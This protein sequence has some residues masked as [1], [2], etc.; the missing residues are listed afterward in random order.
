MRAI[1]RKRILLGLWVVRTA[2]AL[3]KKQGYKSRRKVRASIEAGAL[4][5][6]IS[7]RDY[8]PGNPPRRESHQIPLVL[9]QKKLGGLLMREINSTPGRAGK[10]DSPVAAAMPPQDSEQALWFAEHLQPHEAMLRAWLHSRFP[11]LTDLDDIIQ[12]AYARVLAAHARQ[13]MRSPKAFFFATA[14]NLACD[15]YRKA[16]VTIA[17]PVGGFDEFSVLDET[18]NITETVARNQEIELMTQAIQSLPDRC[19][20][21]LTLRYVYGLPHSEIAAQLGISPRT[22]EAQ[23]TTGTKRCTQFIAH[24]RSR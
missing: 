23:I 22:V 20:Q 14:R 18:V 10:K 15:H 13:E 12:E 17:D 5:P 2:K 1:L 7:I 16:K 8:L 3:R 11:K 4:H 24:L 9:L 21:V 6:Y 19:R